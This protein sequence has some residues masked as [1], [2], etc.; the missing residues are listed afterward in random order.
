MLK[1]S[2]A[3]FAFLAV[4]FGAVN[5]ATAPQQDST[6][7]LSHIYSPGQHNW[8][9]YAVDTMSGAVRAGCAAWDK[10]RGPFGVLGK[11]H[12]GQCSSNGVITIA[13]P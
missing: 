2:L 6:G 1:S 5:V 7:K 8:T 11:E 10:P 3:I 12:W 4:L 13:A 9:H